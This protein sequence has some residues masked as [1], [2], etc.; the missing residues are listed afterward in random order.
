MSLIMDLLFPAFA[1]GEEWHIESGGG[2]GLNN[3]ADLKDQH[4]QKIYIT[5]SF[6]SSKAGFIRIPSYFLSMS[7]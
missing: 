5:L 4:D 1:E 3:I 6:Y 2:Y 7:F